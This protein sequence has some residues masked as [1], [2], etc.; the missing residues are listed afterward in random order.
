MTILELYNQYESNRYNERHRNYQET[1]YWCN[2]WRLLS[3]QL[4]EH[5]KNQ[6]SIAGSTKSKAKSKAARK[7]GKLG[8]RPRKDIK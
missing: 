5:I 6:Y 3:T 8:G 4:I 2:Q 7:N 1:S